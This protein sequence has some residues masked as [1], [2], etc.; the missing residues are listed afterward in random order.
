MT[1]NRKLLI[2]KRRISFQF[3]LLQPQ[4]ICLIN[5]ES[6]FNPCCCKHKKFLFNQRRISFQSKLL[7]PQEI[8]LI[9]VESFF[10]PSCCKHKKFLFNQRRISFQSKLMQPQEICLINVESVFNPS[11]SNHKK[12]QNSKITVK[13]VVLR[14][15]SWSFEHVQHSLSNDKT[16]KYVDEGYE[17][18][19]CS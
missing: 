18:S 7:Q 4:E 19:C 8:C 5:V 14:R 15:I 10:N 12:F 1:G 16:S 2:S 9:N 3:K 17:G 11:R 13:I 6:V